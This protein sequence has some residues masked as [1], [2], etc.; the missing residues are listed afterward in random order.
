MTLVAKAA[1]ESDLGAR[2]PRRE[3]AP[4][5]ADAN[6]IQ[7]G[8]RRQAGFLFEYTQKMERAQ[9]GACGQVVERNAGGV[10]IMQHLPGELGAVAWIRSRRTGP[11]C[12]VEAE[13]IGESENR[14]GAARERIARYLE[15]MIQANQAAR[16]VV[17]DNHAL[18]KSGKVIAVGDF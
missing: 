18:G 12:G 2:H 1:F 5:F 13:E 16:H 14:G 3:P 15:K 6:L 9:A 17:I 7:I 8:V 4:R 11:Q 10:T